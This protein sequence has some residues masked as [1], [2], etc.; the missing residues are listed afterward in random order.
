MLYFIPRDE[1]PARA[2][3]IDHN[4]TSSIPHNKIQGE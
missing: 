1:N 2:N 4:N 3:H